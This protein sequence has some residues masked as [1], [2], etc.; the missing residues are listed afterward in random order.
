M[1]NDSISPGEGKIPCLLVSNRIGLFHIICGA[2]LSWL[3][4]LPRVALLSSWTG[5][6]S[7]CLHGRSWWA[8][9]P[10]CGKALSILL[11]FEHPCC[12]GL[13][14]IWLRTSSRFRLWF[15]GLCRCY[16][17]LHRTAYLR[18]CLFL[19]VQTLVEVRLR[20][21]RCISHFLLGR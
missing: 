1:R 7:W 10:G 12:H 11:S 8:I 14:N 19:E 2:S 4:G 21:I 17:F 15:H 16:L 9:R 18:G 6:L 13:K 3:V 5:S 20:G